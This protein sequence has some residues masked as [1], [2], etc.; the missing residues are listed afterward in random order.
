MRHYRRSA[1]PQT[2]WSPTTSPPSRTSREGNTFQPPPLNGHGDLFSPNRDG[3]WEFL[4]GS[5]FGVG[6][7]KVKIYNPVSRISWRSIRRRSS[8]SLKPQRYV[9]TTRKSNIV[10]TDYCLQLQSLCEY[11]LAPASVLTLWVRASIHSYVLTKGT[12]SWAWN[13]PSNTL[14]IF[15]KF[16]FGRGVASTAGYGLSRGLHK[17]GHQRWTICPCVGVL[18]NIDNVLN[19]PASVLKGIFCFPPPSVCN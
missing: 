13:C 9:F 2:S 14:D 6:G 3:K 17:D 18:F 15:L 8:K 16:L 12:I 5:I 4:T 11:K 1:R 10:L 19:I 7:F